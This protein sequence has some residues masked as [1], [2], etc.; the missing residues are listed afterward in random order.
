MRCWRTGVGGWRCCWSTGCLSSTRSR[1]FCGTRSPCGPLHTNKCHHSLSIEPEIARGG[2]AAVRDLAPTLEKHF[3]PHNRNVF[4]FSVRNKGIEIV[5]WI[6]LLWN[7]S[8]DFKRKRTVEYFL[9]ASIGSVVPPSRSG[10]NNT[11]QWRWNVH[12]Q[13]AKVAEQFLARR[14]SALRRYRR[15]L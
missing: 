1:A 11:E 5:C 12:G 4:I 15:T 2:M 14:L 9:Q 8:F 10:S 6:L 13:L 7:V 3:L